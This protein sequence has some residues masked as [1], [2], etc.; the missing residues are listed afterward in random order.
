[1]PFNTTL[2]PTRVRVST[3]FLKM[4]Y[5]VR[6]KSFNSYGCGTKHKLMLST[7]PRPIFTRKDEKGPKIFVYKKNRTKQNYEQL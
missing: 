5:S 3:L 7:S 4:F 1:M 2:M 6:V